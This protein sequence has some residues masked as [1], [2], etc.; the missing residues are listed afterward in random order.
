MWTHYAFV[1]AYND[2]FLGYV[3]LFGL[4]V[5]TLLSGVL[6]T[7]AAWFYEAAHDDVSTLIYGGF[8]GFATVAL[9]FM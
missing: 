7:D 5:F 8:L 2:F 9:G 1:I 6:T 3:A 4:S